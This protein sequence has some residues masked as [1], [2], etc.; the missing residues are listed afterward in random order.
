MR[1]EPARH[2]NGLLFRDEP[3]PSDADAVHEIVSSSGFFSN[4]E[5]EI[6]LELLQ[7]RIAKGV[8]SG[9]YF[10]FAE[11]GGE[12]IG[13]ACFGPIPCTLSSFDLYWIAVRPALRGSGIGR[14]IIAEA[15][16]EVRKLGGTRIYVETS[17]REL[18]LPTR[19]FYL[20]CGYRQEGV[21]RDFYADGDNKVVFLKVL[22]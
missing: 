8:S 7:E 17:S 6:A 22:P 10:L 21:F 11:S 14:R 15:E 18:Y 5:I 3:H 9:Y 4:A 2:P 19:E 1:D 13:Y 16:A 12:V 20:K